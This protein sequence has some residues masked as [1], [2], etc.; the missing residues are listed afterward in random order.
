MSFAKCF[1]SHESD[2]CS[3]GERDPEEE[4]SSR[5]MTTQTTGVVCDPTPGNQRRDQRELDLWIV[6]CNFVFD[7]DKVMEDLYDLKKIFMK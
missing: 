6:M 2:E 7:V 5:L 3:H 1:A 4:I